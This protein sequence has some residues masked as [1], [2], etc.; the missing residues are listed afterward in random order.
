MTAF[1]LGVHMPSVSVI[2]PAFNAE[3]YIDECLRSV[4]KQ[5]LTDIEIIVVDDGS[6]DATVEH[7]ESHRAL[8]SRIRLIKQSNQFAGVARNK[9]ISV[10]RGDYL[11]FLD[12]D[13]W[14]EP[15]S[16]EVLASAANNASA[17]IVVA[18]SEGF[19]SQNGSTWLIDYA[20]NNVPFGT[21][22]HVEDYADHLFQSFMGWPWDKLYRTSFVVSHGF[23]FQPLRTTND[24]LFVFSSLA[25]AG[26]V[27]CCDQILFHHRS[28]NAKS[29]EGS[30]DLSWHCAIDA[31][32]AINQKIQSSSHYDQLKHSYCNWVMNYSFWSI[33]TL[34]PSVAEMYLDALLPIVSKMPRND[35]YYPQLHERLFSEYCD[36]N[37]AQLLAS[38]V[39][40]KEINSDLEN[41]KHNLECRVNNLL[42]DLDDS[43]LNNENLQAELIEAREKVTDLYA[44]HSYRFGNFVMRPLASLKNRFHF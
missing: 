30:R 14:I 33:S 19:D 38:L 3:D 31:M 20:L 34:S 5:S 42:K 4:E 7:V 13:D 9:G 18:R 29:L 44:S 37:R 43:R 22:L 35:D 26:S 21:V 15:N 6:T 24:A 16:L 1:V 11:Y 27:Y 41:T 40:S 8:D 28:N 10:A 25:F 32:V 17:D 12:A 39:S 2:I 23:S 36:F